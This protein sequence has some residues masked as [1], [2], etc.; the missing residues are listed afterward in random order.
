MRLSLAPP[1]ALAAV[2]ITG[3]GSSKHESSAATTSAASSSPASTTTQGGKPAGAEPSVIALDEHALTVT[4]PLYKGQTAAGNPTYYVV[5]DA[6][7]GVAAKR[8][9]VNVAAKLTRALG[10]KAVQVVHNGP[11]GIVFAGTVD[12]T[13]K[14]VVI[15]SKEGFPPTVAKPGAVGDAKYSPLITTGDGTV[16]DA[17]QVANDTGIGN[18]VVSI[19]YTAKTVTLKLLEGFVGGARN[20][21]VRTDGSIPLL[22]A[23]ESSTYAPNLNAAPRVGSDSPASSSRSGIVPVVNGPRASAGPS[24]RQGLQ[25]ALLGEGP[26]ENIEQD[27]PSSSGYS[28]LWDVTPVVWTPQAIGAHKVKRLTSFAAVAS[29]FREGDLTSVGMGPGNATVGAKELGAISNCSIVSI[30]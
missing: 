26:P 9:G 18:G 22:A 11:S 3:C 13:H 30:G 19:D 15:P 10:T 25:S 21:Y 5:T 12:F 1:I 16:V 23:I 27:P 6:S 20:F 7:S 8:Y 28:P 4:L 14:P 24:E 2:L 17:P 29:A